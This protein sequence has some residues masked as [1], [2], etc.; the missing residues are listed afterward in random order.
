[1]TPCPDRLGCMLPRAW[2]AA[3]VSRARGLDLA[4]LLADFFVDY[5]RDGRLDP[6]MTK[7]LFFL[8]EQLAGRYFR[9][10]TMGAENLPPTAGASIGAATTPGTDAARRCGRWPRRNEDASLPEFQIPRPKEGFR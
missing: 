5:P 4:A 9:V 6:V 3:I 8:V 10:K 1:M 7:R 2:Q